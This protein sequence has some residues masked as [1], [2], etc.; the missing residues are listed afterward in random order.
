[1]ILLILIVK[2]QCSEIRLLKFR[3]K[4]TR[5]LTHAQKIMLQNMPLMFHR[6]KRYIFCNKIA[7]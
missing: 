7:T 5:I 2:K 3:C 6:N 4:D 1:M